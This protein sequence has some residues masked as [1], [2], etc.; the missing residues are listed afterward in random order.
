MEIENWLDEGQPITDDL[1][2]DDPA[3]VYIV[4]LHNGERWILYG[5]RNL[6]SFALELAATVIQTF[7]R[8]RVIEISSDEPR[9][10]REESL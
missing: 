10:I 6:Q 9:I 8:V 5:F 3:G 2:D 1:V 7:N 4:Q